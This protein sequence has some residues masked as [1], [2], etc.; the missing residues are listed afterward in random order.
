[1]RAVLVVMPILLLSVAACTSE[2]DRAYAEAQKCSAAITNGGDCSGNQTTVAPG[3][4]ETSSPQPSPKLDEPKKS[5][6][7]ESRVYLDSTE[8]MRGF[9]SSSNSTFT[10]LIESISYAMPG[11]RLFKYGMTGKRKVPS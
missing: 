7:E 3:P 1:M 5:S 8:S 10:K 9:A 2:S 6:I 4:K 11:C